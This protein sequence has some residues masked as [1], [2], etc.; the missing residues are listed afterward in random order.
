MNQK[1]EEVEEEGPKGR[2]TTNFFEMTARVEPADVNIW[3]RRG[4]FR[5]GMMMLVVSL[6]FHFGSLATDG[7]LCA[8]V[9]TVP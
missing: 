3:A 2:Q 4:F 9:G 7:V 6:K 8:L 5:I 1:N